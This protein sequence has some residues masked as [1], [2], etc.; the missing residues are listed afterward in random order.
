MKP[1][2]LQIAI[3]VLNILYDCLYSL[4]RKPRTCVKNVLKF[5]NL[6]LQEY[7]RRVLFFHDWASSLSNYLCQSWIQNKLYVT[8]YFDEDFVASDKNRVESNFDGIVTYP[9]VDGK[10]CVNFCTLV[11]RT[12]FSPE[13]K[14]PPLVSFI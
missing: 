14:L 9:E 1:F 11:S 7:T 5:A 12:R 3:L 6:F 13:G 2:H 4:I 10:T 8:L